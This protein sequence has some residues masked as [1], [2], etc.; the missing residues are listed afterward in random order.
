MFLH[1]YSEK[2]LRSDIESSGL[3]ITNLYRLN[4]ESSGLLSSRWFSHLRAGG[5]IAIAHRVR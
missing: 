2:E 5:F 3:Q 4:R 1:I